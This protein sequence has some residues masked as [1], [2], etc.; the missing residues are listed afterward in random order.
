MR[1]RVTVR[2]ARLQLER[3]RKIIRE[4]WMHE[5][6]LEKVPSWGTVAGRRF[7][8]RVSIFVNK[9]WRGTIKLLKK[10]RR[11]ER[12]QGDLDVSSDAGSDSDVSID[13]D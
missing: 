3:A 11:Q 4:D 2:T 6:G 5:E 13:D 8:A 7:V 12:G 9:G 1:Q 10:V